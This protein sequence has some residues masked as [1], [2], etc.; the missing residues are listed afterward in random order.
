MKVS[1]L[2]PVYN[3]QDYLPGSLDSILKNDL[4]DCEIV[5]VDDGATDR[6][7]EICDEYASRYPGLIRVVHQPNGGIGEAR[8]SCLREARGEWLLFVDSD[9][10]V[11]PDMLK[12][13]RNTIEDTD[14]EIIGFQ[15]YADNGSD[16]PVVQSC[17]I[18]ASAEPFRLAE[19]KEYLLTLP[20][21]WLRCWKRSLFTQSGLTFPP[22][23]WYEDFRMV[24]KIL[25][26][27][28]KI[29]I[30]DEPLYY[31]LRR[32][33][34][35]MNNEKLKRNREILEAMDDILSWYEKLG[36]LETYHDELEA[37]TIQHVLLAASTRVARYDPKHP[38]L[39]E[40]YDY[41]Q[42]HF[43]DWRKNP[44]TKQLP[45]TK[46]LALALIRH[47]AYGTL[48]LLFKLK[49]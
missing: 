8:N 18:A 2:V 31:Y 41:T 23:V 13:L 46:R 38:L 17:G 45:G 3:V 7:G 26:L 14:A 27:A 25:P 10:K 6:S 42:T 48:R 20:S 39:L 19:R 49:G 34:S 5:L 30:I 29:R 1:I 37:L 24:S 35:I 47:R 43:P 40:F 9:D 15:F 44:Y 32:P 21:L 12:I 33:G 16:P 22:L 11:R 28:E 36:L 4:E